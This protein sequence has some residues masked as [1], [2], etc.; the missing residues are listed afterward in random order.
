MSSTWMIGFCADS[1]SAAKLTETDVSPGMLP[2]F[3]VNI[4]RSAKAN[5][6]RIYVEP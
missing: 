3:F 5:L 4:R 2:S 1:G 6:F